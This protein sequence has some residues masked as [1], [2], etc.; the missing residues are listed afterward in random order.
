MSRGSLRRRGA[1]SWE[2]KFD[3]GTDPLTGRRRIRYASFKGNKRDAALELAR[4]VAEHASGAGVDPS[5]ASVVEFLGRWL[6][7][8]SA[9]ISRK[10]HERYCEIVRLYITPHIG[11]FPIQKLRPAHLVDLYTT[12]QERGGSQGASLSPR[13]VGHVHRI[14]RRGLGLAMTWGVTTTNVA[15]AVKP[16][17]VPHG[18]IPVLSHDQ[19][20]LVL[21]HLDGQDLRPV[22]SFLL[23]TG[24][25]RGEALALRWKDLDLEKGTVRIERSLEHTRSGVR[26]KSPKTAH[27]RRSITIA[28]WLVAEL[29][30]HHARQ[31]EQRLALGLG[32]PADDALVFARWDGSP[33][34]PLWAT[35]KFSRTMRA[36]GIANVTLHAL[37]HTHASALIASGIDVLTVSRRLG[38]ASAAITLGTYGHLFANTD[39]R[40]AEVT[41]ALFSKVPN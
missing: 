19:I 3:A 26:V 5:K 24:C 13:S 32:K 30:A 28:P 9:H 11:A 7:W 22:V 35:Q 29:R 36:L 20:G 8:A 10:T 18:E 27:S 31:L 14:L 34:V 38:H 37:R 1:Q 41:E 33:H 40:A 39:S 23:G 17:P 21:R 4:L 15:T 25:R 6:D 16:P 2:L 12:L